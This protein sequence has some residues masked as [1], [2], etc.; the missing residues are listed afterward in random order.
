[1]KKTTPKPFNHIDDFDQIKMPSIDELCW[2]D[3]S[4]T[5]F[6]D[7]EIE[8]AVKNHLKNLPHQT[9]E[10][11]SEWFDIIAAVF[12]NH[13]D[14]RWLAR[15]KGK[16]NPYSLRDILKKEEVLAHALFSIQRKGIAHSNQTFFHDEWTIQTNERVVQSIEEKRKSIEIFQ[17]A[18]LISSQICLA[19]VNGRLCKTIFKI[20]HELEEE[21]DPTGE[22]G[23]GVMGLT[24][25]EVIKVLSHAGQGSKFH[26]DQIKSLIRENIVTLKDDLAAGALFDQD[27]KIQS[28]PPLARRHY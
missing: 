19:H 13:F 28:K 18:T 15:D 27:V 4:K 26:P 23:I 1:M 16:L 6:G 17:A 24:A 25:K 21:M 11:L 2:I 8:R 22:N 20:Q 3:H 5:S 7:Y 9:I 14:P 12:S 10:E